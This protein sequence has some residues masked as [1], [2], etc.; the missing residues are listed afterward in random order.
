[1]SRTPAAWPDTLL[2]VRCSN[3]L[4]MLRCCLL[5][6]RTGL[7]RE[8]KGVQGGRRRRK[9]AEP[10]SGGRGDVTNYGP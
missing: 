4:H 2:Q 6:S 5:E 3:T 8:F 9:E 1:M 10:G 7:H